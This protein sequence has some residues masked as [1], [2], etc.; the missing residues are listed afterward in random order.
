ML[1]L[2]K[3]HGDF[4]DIYREFMGILRNLRDFMVISI[5][6]IYEVLMVIIMDLNGS[7]SRDLEMELGR[8]HRDTI[9][10][11]ARSP[12]VGMMITWFGGDWNIFYCHHAN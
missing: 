4:I 11:W 2:R 9:R 5:F 7:C 1:I 10:S 6:W 8:S 3:L 12:R